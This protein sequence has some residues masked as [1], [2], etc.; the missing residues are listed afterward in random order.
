MDSIDERACVDCQDGASELCWVA[1]PGENYSGSNVHGKPEDF[2]RRFDAHNMAKE[3]LVVVVSTCLFILG[4]A[5]PSLKY[6]SFPTLLQTWH[7]TSLVMKDAVDVIKSGSSHHRQVAHSM[8]QAQTSMPCFSD[9][10]FQR[11]SRFLKRIQ[12][13]FGCFAH[14]RSSD[15]CVFCRE[16]LSARLP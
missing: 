7:Y 10:A 8:H 6:I 3:S 2:S 4:G 5:L 9:L 13:I 14:A 12:F 1:E 11:M 16:K 15:E